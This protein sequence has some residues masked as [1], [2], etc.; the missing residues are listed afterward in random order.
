M[1]PALQ[2][3]SFHVSSFAPCP[4]SIQYKLVREPPIHKKKKKSLL[5]FTSER[6]CAGVQRI[7]AVITTPLKKKKR[8]K[9]PKWRSHH[10]RTSASSRCSRVCFVLN[11]RVGYYPSPSTSTF[12]YTCFHTTCKPC[13]QV[14]SCNPYLFRRTWAQMVNHAPGT[15]RLCWHW[16]NA[17]DCWV[18]RTL[19]RTR[20]PSV[21][22]SQAITASLS[23]HDS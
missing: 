21:K 7:H 10:P 20:A 3:V 18:R 19:M 12:G 6:L 23:S 15:A 22:T 13:L 9:M 2:L 14:L 8:L 4:R 1:L 16:S 17:L 11:V 5:I